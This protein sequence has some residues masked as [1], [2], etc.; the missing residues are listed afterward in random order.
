MQGPESLL[1][2]FGVC[3]AFVSQHIFHLHYQ[4]STRGREEPFNNVRVISAI[5]CALALSISCPSV[6]E[7]IAKTVAHPHSPSAT[8]PAPSPALETSNAPQ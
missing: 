1:G 8:P 4:E 2:V 6:A 3:V 5:H 7:S